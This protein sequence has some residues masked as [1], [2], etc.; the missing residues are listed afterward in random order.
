M[1]NTINKGNYY[2]IETQ[3]RI[4]A[5]QNA[6][7]FGNEKAY[8]E[9]RNRWENAPSDGIFGEYP[10]NI[11]FD[12]STVCNLQCPYCYTVSGDYKKRI[13]REFMEFSLFKK[14]IDEIADRVPAIRVVARGEPTL[15]PDFIKFINY[16]KKKGVLEVGA[17]TNLSTMTPEF[18]EKL[19]LAGLDWFTISF[20][21]LDEDY[22]RNRYPLKFNES[23]EK[24]QKIKEIKERYDIPKPA[25]TVQALWSSIQDY[26]DSF[27]TRLAQV[28]DSISFNAQVDFDRVDEFIDCSDFICAHIY[29]RLLILPS[30]KVFPCC[31][32]GLSDFSD[33]YYVGDV[34]NQ[35]IYEIWNGP[36]ISKIR[37]LHKS[38]DYKK[39]KMCQRCFLTKEMYE[40]KYVV[41]GREFLVKSYL[42]SKVEK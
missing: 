38:G 25:V 26:P 1:S 41:D 39:L 9:Y 11:D 16:A 4:E 6:R 18:F 20:D 23:Y 28:C 22:E 35:F 2:T 33:E 37:E 19:M 24:L 8:F 21:G 13:K 42:K 36:T 3:E 12:I 30:G 7:A 29:Q 10:I 27:Y 5:F 32:T 40:E 17:I 14:V 31:G 15:N 34:N